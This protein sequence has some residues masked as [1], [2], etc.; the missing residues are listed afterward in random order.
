MSFFLPNYSSHFQ[1]A[2]IPNWWHFLTPISD[3][4]KNRMRTLLLFSITM[5]FGCSTTSENAYYLAQGAR[6]Q[7]CQKL[8]EPEFSQ[9]LAEAQQSYDTYAKKR[10]GSD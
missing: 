4:D 9:C 10:E 6:E 2:A 3:T 5:L 1:K 8:Q 7:S